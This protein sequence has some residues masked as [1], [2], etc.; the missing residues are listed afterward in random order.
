VSDQSR[1][2]QS[3][4]PMQLTS[5]ERVGASVARGA[6]HGT[7][8]VL[9]WSSRSLERLDNSTCTVSSIGWRRRENPRKCLSSG[10]A[11][12]ASSQRRLYPSFRRASGTMRRS[13]FCWA[14][15][16]PTG[17]R[18]ASE[19]SRS[20][21]VGTMSFV[22]IPSPLRACSV[23][24]GFRA[25]LRRAGSPTGRASPH[26]AFARN[27]YAPTTS[28]RTRPRSEER[29]PHHSPCS[30]G[31]PPNAPLSPWCR[32]PSVRALGLDLHLLDTVRADHTRDA[33]RLRPLCLLSG[34]AAEWHIRRAS[35]RIPRSRH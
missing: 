1:A 28:S 18:V 23:R 21:Q 12:P 15:A 14:T 13:D 22:T 32:V 24:N 11:L 7:G 2:L 16:L 3:N 27:V 35:G 31:S 20:H 33:E 8:L 30:S 34:L 19:P 10:R 25:S 29:G 5:P 17:Y 4:Q 6:S 26:F 9:F